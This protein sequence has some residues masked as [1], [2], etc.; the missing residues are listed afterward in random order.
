MT[1]SRGSTWCAADKSFSRKQFTVM[2]SSSPS[3]ASRTASSSWACWEKTTF[4]WW[5]SWA[6]RVRSRAWSLMRSKSLMVCSSVLTRWLSATLILRLDSW[7][8][9]VPMASS[10]RSDSASS[11]STSAAFFSSHLCIRAMVR[12]TPCRPKSAMSAVVEKLRS[13]AAAGVARRR[14]S[15]SWTSS[16]SAAESGMVQ[17]ASFSRNPDRG[18]INAVAARLKPV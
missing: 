12:V 18:S 16:C 9:Y 11:R 3:A 4:F 10:Y 8:R 1:C 7:T 15:S 14:G 17:F 2:D 13:T 5:I 6:V